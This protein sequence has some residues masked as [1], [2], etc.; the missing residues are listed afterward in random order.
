MPHEITAGVFLGERRV[1]TLTFA[2]EITRFDYTDVE[3][4]HPVLGLS[5][6]HI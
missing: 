1:G 4:G 6:I 2:D 3:P 5:L